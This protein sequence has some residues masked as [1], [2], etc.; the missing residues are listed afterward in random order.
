MDK[1]YTENSLL[2]MPISKYTQYIFLGRI[3]QTGEVALPFQPVIVIEDY[4]VQENFLA[5]KNVS[6]AFKKNVMI[7]FHLLQPYIKNWSDAKDKR[8]IQTLKKEKEAIHRVLKALE[9]VKAIALI[10][11]AG[12]IKGIR[13]QNM[14]GRG[15]PLPPR[16]MGQIPY[17][18]GGLYGSFLKD[19]GNGEITLSAGKMFQNLVKTLSDTSGINW[20][21]MAKNEDRSSAS[22]MLADRC[23]GLYQY[24]KKECKDEMVKFNLQPKDFIGEFLGNDDIVKYLGRGL[25]KNKTKPFY[26]HLEY[27]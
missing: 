3:E 1:Y 17:I 11:K 25:I 14:Q 22:R 5:S 24:L 26:V 7:Y 27:K 20:I 18:Y 9:S 16:M 8:Y 6:D 2:A 15:Y 12:K 13:V 4:P 19:V 10:V 21:L 23:D